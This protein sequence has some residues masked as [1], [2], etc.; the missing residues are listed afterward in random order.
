MTALDA[1]SGT[2]DHV[3]VHVCF[4]GLLFNT[5]RLPARKRR[6]ACGAVIT[7]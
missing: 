6:N 1:A 7:L 3:P 2:R 5:A 4:Q